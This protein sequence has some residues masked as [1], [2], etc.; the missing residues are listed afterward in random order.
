MGNNPSHFKGNNLPV[1]KISWEKA[2]AF[3]AKLNARDDSYTSRLPSEAEWEYAARA[4]TTGEYVGDLEAM[5]WY[6]GN[7]RGH[8]HPVGSKRP[9][10][11]GL[12]DM[13]GNVWEWCQDWYHDSYAGAPTDGSAWVS[14]DEQKGHVLRGG[15]WSY[16]KEYF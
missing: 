6:S 1:E 7:S 11:F 15:S 9:N 10:A 16:G 13:Y 12:F 2:V 3:I 14:G 8:T 5:T 4:G